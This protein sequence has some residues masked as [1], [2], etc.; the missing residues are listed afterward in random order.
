M[1]EILW[2]PSVVLA[3]RVVRIPV[4]TSEEVKLIAGSAQLVQQAERVNDVTRFFVRMP[5]VAGE[6]TL[7][8]VTASAN[9]ATTIQVVTLAE[10]RAV[11]QRAGNIYPRRWPLGEEY[12]SN[13]QG[14]TWSMSPRSL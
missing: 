13:K 6:V 10:C 12:I 3:G 8:F 14:A 7:Q 11:H 5:Y 4:R 9:V 2:S 1:P